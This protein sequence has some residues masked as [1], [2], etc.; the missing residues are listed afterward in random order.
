M[1]ASEESRVFRAPGRV[2]LIGEHTDYAGGLVLPVALDLSC[3]VGVSA[4]DDGRLR[5][6]SLDLKKEASWEV[7]RIPDLEPRGDWS[8]YA[9]GVAV[10]LARRG[11]KIFP[12]DLSLSSTVPLGAGLSSSAAMEVSVALALVSLDGADVS[13]KDLAQICQR[14][15]SDFVGLACGIMDQFASL[16]GKRDHAVLIDCRSLEHSLVALPPGLEIVLLD[17]GVKHELATSAYNQRRREFEAAQAALGKQLR[18][19]PVDQWPAFEAKLDDPVRRRARHIVTENARVIEFVAASEGRDLDRMGELMA[20]SHRSL[21]D[22]YEVS[23]MELDFLVETAN[24]AKGLIGA[25]M[26]GGGFGG[27]TVNLVERNNVSE[28]KAFVSDRFQRRF[29]AAP[30]VYVCESADAAQ[31]VVSAR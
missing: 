30:A 23:C 18:D 13:R 29:G 7:A 10:E 28:F 26:T 2:N 1:A 3:Q 11:V 12:A 21:R 31:E 20:Q 16:F 14:A 4:R 19:I 9:A 25:R 6:R 15:E 27:C 8:D 24:Q 5:I 22:D 17:S